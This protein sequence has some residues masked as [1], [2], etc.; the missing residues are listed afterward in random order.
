MM[1]GFFQHIPLEFFVFCAGVFGAAAGSFYHVCVVR[2]PED[3]SIVSPGSH[4]PQC[5]EPIHWYNNVPV[6]SYL[7]LGGACPNCKLRI[8]PRYLIFELLSALAFMGV[9]WRFGGTAASVPTVFLY[10]FLVSDLLIISGIDWDHQYIPDEL[11]IPM[12][13]V[14]L[15]MGTLAQ[16]TGWFPLALVQT[17][18]DA[19]LGLVVGGGLIWSIRAIG[20]IIFQQEAMGFGDVKLMAFLGGFLGWQEALLCIFLAAFFGSIVGISMK[21]AGKLE[22][23]GKIPF[24]PYLALGAY[25]CL[26]F[27]PEII[28]WYTEPFTTAF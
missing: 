25:C 9:V 22:K 11:S 1:D 17:F 26:L 10:L 15:A 23:Y 2:I 27:G 14:A 8:P 12:S 21:L 13:F 3:Q 7:L 20:T 5:N 16:W 18:P 6:F 19:L 24:G 4:C 28:A